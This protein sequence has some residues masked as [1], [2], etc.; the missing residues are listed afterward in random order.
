MNME[1]KDSG[2]GVISGNERVLRARLSDA[3]FFWDQDRKCTLRS[4]IPALKDRIFHAKIGTI[5]EKVERMGTLALDI[6]K[7]VPKVDNDLIL[8][9]ANL[10]KADLSTG[11]VGE[12]PE[13]QGIIGRYYAL[14]DGE[15]PDVADAVAQHYS[16]AGPEDGCQTKPL[17]IAIGLADKFDSLVGFWSINEKPT[18]SKDPYALRRASLGIIRLIIE[19]K[20][21]IPLLKIFKL[22]QDKFSFD[23]DLSR[24]LRSFLFERMK[25]YL[26][27][28]GERHDVIEAVFSLDTEDDLIRLMS[29]FRALSQFLDHGEGWRLLDGY[30][31]IANIV[32]IEER[33]DGC[34]FSKVSTNDFEE[35]DIILWKRLNNTQGTIE[36]AL[37]DEKF[38]EALEVLAQLGPSIDNF[39]DKVKINTEN[40]SIR[41]NRLG[42]LQK[43]IRLN[44]RVADFS[45][46]E[47]GDKTIP[48]CP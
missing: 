6:A 14:H 31:R 24:E 35:E 39:F 30:R 18:G 46:I 22:S 8:V 25:V 44:D 37:K 7:Y 11:M 34:K 13:L 17:S 5:A 43:I 26:R 1:T 47:G 36:A 33:K 2:K 41:A 10:A 9:A 3:A 12:F 23:V 42:L 29:R 45:K 27:D 20:L 38:G 28:K 4:R 48:K 21:R 15:S 16:P 19:N 32:R 40:A